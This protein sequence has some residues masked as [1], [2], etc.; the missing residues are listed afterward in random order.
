MISE[1]NLYRRCQ[2]LKFVCFANC[3]VLCPTKPDVIYCSVLSLYGVHCT[4]LDCWTSVPQTEECRYNCSSG[5][6]D[7]RVYNHTS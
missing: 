3:T 5:N 6:K 4:V 2:Q 7:I 1:C